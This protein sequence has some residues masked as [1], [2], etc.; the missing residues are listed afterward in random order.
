M[1]VT[2]FKIKSILIRFAVENDY[3]ASNFASSVLSAVQ[4]E[5]HLKLPLDDSI[6]QYIIF[7]AKYVFLRNVTVQTVFRIVS[8]VTITN[9]SVV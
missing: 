3:A 5:R 4:V 1:L 6:S 2:L 8:A 9:V 7:C